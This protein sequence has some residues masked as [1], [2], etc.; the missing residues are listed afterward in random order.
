MIENFNPFGTGSVQRLSEATRKL[1]SQY[2][3]CD[4][5]GEI[6]E[7]DF[8]IDELN[9]PQDTPEAVYHGKIAELIATKTPIIVRPEELLVGNALLMPAVRH[10]VPAATNR[11]SISH[12]TADFDD[13]ITK[14]L[15]G[16]SLE[17]T[18]RKVGATSEQQEFCDGLLLT[19]KAMRI[20]RDRYIAECQKQISQTTDDKAINNLN[21]I[22]KV[23][24][25][26][27]E[28]PAQSYREAVQSLWFFWEFQRVCGNWSGLGRVDQILGSYLERD[29]ANKVITLDEARELLAHFWIKGAEWYNAL[30]ISKADWSGTGDA[31]NYQNVVLGGLTAQGTNLENE[32]TFLVLDIIEELHISDFPVAVRLNSH[33]STKLL[34]R[35]ADVQLLGGG[36]VSVYNERVVMEGFR[37]LGYPEEEIVEF[38]NDGCWEVLIP[39]KTYFTYTPFDALWVFQQM[40]FEVETP[41][42][43]EELYQSHVE[44]LRKWIT[45]FKLDIERWRNESLNPCDV[46]LSLVMPSC[47]QSACSYNR[48]GSKYNV[49]AIHAGGMPDVANSLL[50]IKKF[51]YEQNRLTFNEMIEVIKS[52]FEGNEA[53]RLEFANSIKYYGN[54]NDEAD[55][56]LKQVLNDYSDIVNSTPPMPKVLSPVGISTFGREI[57][58]AASRSATPFGKHAHEYLAPNLSPTPGT[59]RESMSAIMNSYCKMDFSKVPS[60]CILDLRLSAGIRALPEAADILVTLYQ[61]FIQKGGFYIQLDTVDVEMLKEAKKNPERFPNLV[62]RISGWSARFATLSEEWQDMIINRTE[63][64]S[65]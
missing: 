24:E 37:A 22:I 29:L 25:N 3:G 51:V 4:F 6:V 30:S 9:L 50:A 34:K 10:A 20:W 5:I 43:F 49:S 61:V 64:E 40:L 44:A 27:P 42:T 59:E 17:I 47:R 55:E 13:A 56:L 38:T 57:S 35:I 7:P 60:G 45:G 32:V 11:G 21:E 41:A 62:V 54:D 58:Y 2:L 12:T 33:T 26:V 1:A 39:G 46:V 53:L 63:L 23:L 31:Q 18:Q 19:I 16:L 65:I 8:H 15:S 48:L 28:N 14:G 36:I 52:D